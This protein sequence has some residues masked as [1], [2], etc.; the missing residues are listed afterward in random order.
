MFRVASYT[1]IG[2][3][4]ENED[5]VRWAEHPDGRLCLLIGVRHSLKVFPE[6]ARP[7]V[8]PPVGIKICPV[9]NTDLLNDRFINTTLPQHLFLGF[10]PDM[11]LS[12]LTSVVICHPYFLQSEFLKM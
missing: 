10:F 9:L 6:V 1:D 11:P 3:R 8:K 5:T 12:V 4:A 2:G 7:S